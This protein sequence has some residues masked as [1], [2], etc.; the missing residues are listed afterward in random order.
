MKLEALLNRD[1]FM[2]VA[3]LN[4]DRFQSLA[5]A[6]LLPAAIGFFNEQPLWSRD[7]CERWAR[8]TLGQLPASA[9][10][11]VMPAVPAS[12]DDPVLTTREAAVFLGVGLAKL[13]QLF[14]DGHIAEVPSSE[15]G[16]HFRQSDLIAV[17]KTDVFNWRLSPETRARWGLKKPAEEGV[18]AS[19][20]VATM[21][22]PRRNRTY[23]PAGL[24]TM[25]TNAAKG[26][27]A[28]AAKRAAQKAVDQA[29]TA[30]AV[31]LLDA[32]PVTGERHVV[33]M[34]GPEDLL[35]EAAAADHLGI[36]AEVLRLLRHDQ[37]GPAV[38]LANGVARYRVADLDAYKSALGLRGR[39]QGQPEETM[40]TPEAA[41]L[42]GIT[43]KALENLRHRKTGPAWQKAGVFVVYR[44]ADLIAWKL[45]K[46]AQGVAALKS[47]AV[48][49]KRLAKPRAS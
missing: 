9:Q 41:D 29:A 48:E 44:R 19:N 31:P 30:P 23:T 2:A 5:M 42:L 24:E 36:H 21:A 39:P 1:E 15:R 7:A 46:Q 11:A 45:Q 25:R 27:A 10:S 16:R 43:A 3:G 33:K 49:L 20:P 34:A 26:R 8:E 47:R 18:A 12:Q 6:G 35:G 4:A 17:T 37:H 28:L 40:H 38:H 22:T 13:A 32:K 14:N